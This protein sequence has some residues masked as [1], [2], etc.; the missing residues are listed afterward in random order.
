MEDLYKHRTSFEYTNS[1]NKIYKWVPGDN[2]ILFNN[3]LK[4]EPNNPNWLYYL[5]N[6]IEYKLNNEGFRTPDD[7]NSTDEGN[8]FLGCSHTF[9]IGHH[10]E[11]TWSY[12]INKLIGGKFWNLSIGGVGVI[13]SFRLL[14]GYYNELNIKNIFHFAPFYPRYEFIINGIPTNFLLNLYSSDFDKQF[15]F[16][17]KDS[18]FNEDQLKFTYDSY[19]YAIKGVASE[20]GINYYHIDWKP[21]EQEYINKDDSL[22]ARDF[23][24]FSTKIHDKI[25]KKFLKMYDI[26][27]FNLYKDNDDYI[28]FNNINNSVYGDIGKIK[29][30][31]TIL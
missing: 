17:C 6:P 31:K 16:L 23:Y 1:A 25:F 14:L 27:L 15:G 9:G 13:T 26:N 28:K 19:I 18:L 20:M 3:L 29:L 4:R 10:L 8:V 11:N 22:Q 5:K 2:E 12:R 7:F 30:N 21:T 24:H